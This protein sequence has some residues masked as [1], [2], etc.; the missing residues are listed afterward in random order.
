MLLQ[1]CFKMEQLA[2]LKLLR[3]EIGKEGVYGI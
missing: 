2:I 1:A 3:R